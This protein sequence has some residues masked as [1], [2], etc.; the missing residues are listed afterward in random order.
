MREE[1]GIKLTDFALFSIKDFKDRKEF[2]YIKRIELNLAKIKLTEGQKLRWF[3]QQEIQK[4]QLAYDFNAILD[5]F[6]TMRE[7]LYDN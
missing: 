2:T 4:I 6:Y 5:H 1:L 7:E 3:N